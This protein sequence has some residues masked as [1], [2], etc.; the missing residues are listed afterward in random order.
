M[1]RIV[2]FDQFDCSKIALSPKVEKNRK[3]GNMVNLGTGPDAKSRV[4]IQTPAMPLPFGVSPYVDASG[5]T[6]SYS[7]DVSFRNADTDPKVADFMARIAQLDELLL[8]TGVERSKEFFGKT[9]TRDMVAE[10]YRKLIKQNNPEYPA[11]LKVKV[12]LLGGE[13]TA[14]FFDEK[15]NP[16]SIDYFTKGTTVRMIVEISSIWFVNK[17]YGVTL[18]L[19]QAQA[20]SRP[21]RLEEFS[22]ADDGTTESSQ[23]PADQFIPEEM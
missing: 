5:Q 3:G 1:D 13:P 2:L 21:N 14:Q 8:N 10:F 17:T 19:I 11:V 20:V 4:I 18:K 9:Y 22:F 15:R 7:L 12:P 6:Q 23:A 16:V